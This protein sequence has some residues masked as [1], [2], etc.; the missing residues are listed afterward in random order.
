MFHL[1]ECE[2]EGLPSLGYLVTINIRMVKYRMSIRIRN[3]C[4]L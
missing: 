1:I 4:I 2:N 3:E